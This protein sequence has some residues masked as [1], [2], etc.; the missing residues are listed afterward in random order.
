MALA[1]GK[2]YKRGAGIYHMRLLAG[3]SGLYK[4]VKW[5]HIVEDEDAT[6]FLHGGEL[7]FTAAARRMAGC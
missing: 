4:L 5:V 7:V 2:L 6:L 1:V 3:K